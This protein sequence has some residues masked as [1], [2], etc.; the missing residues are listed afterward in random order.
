MGEAEQRQSSSGLICAT[1]TGCTGWALSV[2]RQRGLAAELPS[3]E[4]DR[5]AWFVREPFPSVHTQVS[6]DHG[7]I[8]RASGLEVVSEMASGGVA[9]ADGIESDRV[10]F[11]DGATLRVRLSDRRLSLVVESEPPRER[12]ADERRSLSASGAAPSR[13][14]RARPRRGA[15]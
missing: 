1:G 4:E 5:G 11:S 9:F 13:R 15:G 2:A 8:S 10:E 12:E 3:P 14:R 6:L 7:A